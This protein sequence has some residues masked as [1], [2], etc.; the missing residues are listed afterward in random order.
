VDDGDLAAC[1]QGGYI[2]RHALARFLVDRQGE[3]KAPR[4]VELEELADV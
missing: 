1:L 3:G 2:D 4:T